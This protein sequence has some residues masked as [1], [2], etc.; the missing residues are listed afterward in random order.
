MGEMAWRKT[1]EGPLPEQHITIAELR[2]NLNN[3]SE[4]LGAM[5]ATLAY[6]VIVCGE[7]GAGK[8]LDELGSLHISYAKEVEG[9]SQRETERISGEYEKKA[10]AVIDKYLKLPMHGVTTMS[11]ANVTRHIRWGAA[12][13]VGMGA[14][15]VIA[16]GAAPEI[17]LAGAA[18]VALYGVAMGSIKAVEAYE[19]REVRRRTWDLDVTPKKNVPREKKS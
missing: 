13:G 5:S 12:S 16:G 9:K 19:A 3:A 8:L 15:A 4:Q 6:L 18:G 11:F 2:K 7:E 10:T 14:T 17:I 1:R